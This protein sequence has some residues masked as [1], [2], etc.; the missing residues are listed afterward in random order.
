MRGDRLEARVQ[1]AIKTG[2]DV[3]GKKI[4]VVQNPPYTQRARYHGTR[5]R[6]AKRR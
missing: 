1:K 2:I 4:T 3:N 5:P 6:R